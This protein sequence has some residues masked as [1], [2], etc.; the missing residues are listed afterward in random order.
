[1]YQELKGNENFSDKYAT[2][3]IAY[4]LDTDSFFATN[5][6]HFFWEYNDEFQCE[7]D[8]VN[9]FRNHLD[10]FRNVRK[11]ILSHCGG[12]SIDKDLFL[13]NTKERFSNANKKNKHTQLPKTSCSIPMPEVAAIYNPKAIARIKLCGGAVTINV[14]ETMAWKK[15][16]DDQIKNLHDL[17]CIDVEI[18]DSGE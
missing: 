4:C 11:E 5:Q 8:A 3:I 10:E 17:F 18:L 16:T 1:M 13:E 14:D 15:P 9:Y 2:W 12:W 7:S 6:R